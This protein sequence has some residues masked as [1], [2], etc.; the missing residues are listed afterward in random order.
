M[1]VLE[2]FPQPAKNITFADPKD[3]ISKSGGKFDQ[4]ELD[5]VTTWAEMMFGFWDGDYDDAVEAVSLLLFMLAQAVESMEEV[6]QLGK[7]KKELEETELILKIPTAVLVVV[8]F[9]G[10]IAGEIAGLAWVIE[11]AVVVDIFGSTALGVYDAVKNKTSPAVAV[12]DILLGAAGRKMGG[13]HSKAAS[14]RW[15]M[16]AEDVSNLGDVFKRHDESLRKVIPTERC[17]V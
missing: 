8:P 11:A 5:I 13:N 4:L 14:K 17:K 6:K 15:E 16:G 2:D 7:E 3:I 10:E 9:I 12:V 1:I